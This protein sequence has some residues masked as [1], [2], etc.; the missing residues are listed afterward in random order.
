M[1]N[2]KLLRQKFIQASKA[3]PV[4]GH[5]HDI[6]CPD[7]CVGCVKD[8]INC[9]CFKESIDASSLN[10]TS[11][12]NR[13]I[14]VLESPHIKEFESKMSPMPACGYTGSRI[15]H[16]WREVFDDM[17]D[18]YNLI[19]MNA[20]QFQCSMGFSPLQPEIRDNVF[21]RMFCGDC[22]RY[23]VERVELYCRK[24]DVIVLATTNRVREIVR[25]SLKR[26]FS[27]E[28]PHP[29]SWRSADRVKQARKM[30]RSTF[31]RN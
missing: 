6:K 1:C 20:V 22:R 2:D 18:N 16:C 9:R 11:Q 4:G 21:L 7:K 13:F 30:F 5:F 31:F 10:P 23:F 12:R 24:E 3:I 29:S 28:I 26:G 15:R 17:F 27:A 25:Q 8:N 14:L 19:L